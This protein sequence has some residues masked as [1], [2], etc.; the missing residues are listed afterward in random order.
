M[1]ES[2]DELHFLH[3]R[4]ES[5]SNDGSVVLK[6]LSGENI[7]CNMVGISPPMKDLFEK[8][9]EAS[10]INSSILIEGRSGTG[11]KLVARAIHQLGRGDG[12]KMISI[13]CV[14]VH[15]DP[16]ESEIFG[17]KEPFGGIVGER[18]ERLARP[19]EGTFFFEEVGELSLKFQERF[20]RLLD[21]KSFANIRL[22]ASTC[23]DLEEKI[24][25]GDFDRRFFQ[26]FTAERI[27]VPP[28][29]ERKEDIPLLLE[30]F[31]EK[32]SV[33]GD[34]LKIHEQVYRRL[35]SYDWPGNIREL[36]SA[37]GQWAA[38]KRREMVTSGDLPEKFFQE[39]GGIVLL[40]EG[41]DLK[42]VL[43]DIEDS[44]IRQAL[45]MTGDNKNRASKLLRI[46]RTTLIEK[47]KKK[48]NWRAWLISVSK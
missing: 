19:G 4:F 20:L 18:S 27:R 14:S 34:E 1:Q 2:S 42:K 37:V 48:G 8:I 3:S 22:M 29:N 41:I 46:N 40:E 36:E 44:L 17:H 28:L 12:L 38:L 16:L 30:Y 26:H 24:D 6:A 35:L 15:D 7:F 32:Y 25:R 5:S 33:A 13:N 43:S 31:L 45:R 9:R 10:G 39:K 21:T 23:E 11:K 47:M